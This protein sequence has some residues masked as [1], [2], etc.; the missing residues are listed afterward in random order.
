LTDIEKDQELD[1]TTKKIMSKRMRT[2]PERRSHDNRDMILMSLSDGAGTLE[3][4]REN[5]FAFA[6][7]LGIFAPL[8]Q[9]APANYDIFSQ[10]L[11]QD[12]DKMVELGWVDRLG[13][14]Y[15]LSEIGRQQAS[16]HLAGVR[17][18]ASLARN[19]M[20]PETVSKVGV[21]VHFT[22]AALKLPAAILSGSIGLFND[23]ADTLLDGL[24]SLMVYFGIRFDKERAVNIVLVLM[25]LSTGG[26]GFFEA[27]RRFFVPFEPEVDWFTFL[28][29]ILS[30]LV[31]LVLGFYQRYV[32]LKNGNMALITQ[33]ID[34][35]NHVIVAAGVISGLIASL[36]RFALLD[37]VVGVC[38]A[39][40]ILKSGF[41]L[42]VELIRSHGGEASDLSHYEMGLSK[43]YEGFKHAQLRDWMLYLVHTH[44]VKTR[45]ELLDKAS[46]ALD[47]DRYPVLRAFGL[48]NHG[49]SHELIS[50]AL[51][52]LF[53]RG[54]LE[55]NGSLQVTRDGMAH[56]QFEARKV[57]RVMGHSFME[58][59][60]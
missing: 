57:H 44:R 16:E 31:C 10:E 36:L 9:H 34:S 26:L 27:V 52:E 22:L 54:W 1:R 41:D 14:R 47:F 24:A 6:R 21:A 51:A 50:Q 19:L 56:M 40:L 13:E 32:G 48:G 18:V 42:A 11:S 43:R 58:E 29:A 20:R 35:R 8:Y 15:S 37:T 46:Q 53:E 55:E 23:T 12:L 45:A 5:F 59:K 7:R 33:S 4:I 17:K 28:S 49:H 60:L 39:A 3:E 38:I 25:M 2:Y 30:A